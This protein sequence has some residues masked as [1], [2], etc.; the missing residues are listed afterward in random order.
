M[1]GTLQP[2]VWLDDDCVLHLE[3]LHGL[4]PVCQECGEPINLRLDLASFVVSIDHCL[5]HARCVWRAEVFHDQA[6]LADATLV[7]EERTG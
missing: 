6:Q 4:D 2:R 1:G 3:G 7:G 5:V